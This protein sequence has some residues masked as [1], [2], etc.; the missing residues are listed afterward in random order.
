MLES[1]VAKPCSDLSHV[2]FISPLGKTGRVTAR[3]P[4]TNVAQSSFS[5]HH[6]VFI[7]TAVFCLPGRRT[8]IFARS[9]APNQG[10]VDNLSWVW[11]G[12]GCSTTYPI[13]DWGAY[14]GFWVRQGNLH[15]IPQNEELLTWMHRFVPKSK[16]S[17]SSICESEAFP[18]VPC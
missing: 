1:Q 18:S 13:W 15:N 7:A 5:D 4:P 16:V 17:S 11:P 6:E 9:R 3:S 14:L 2:L 10:T 8:S 12:L